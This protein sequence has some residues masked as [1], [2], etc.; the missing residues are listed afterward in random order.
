MVFGV[1]PKTKSP[2]GQPPDQCC[3]LQTTFGDS[4]ATYEK[5]TVTNTVFIT[6]RFFSFLFIIVSCTLFFFFN[7]NNKVQVYYVSTI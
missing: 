4:V 2:I 5:Y 1:G 7:A 6:F 3:F